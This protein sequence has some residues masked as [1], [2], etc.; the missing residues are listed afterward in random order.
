[1]DDTMILHADTGETYGADP[2]EVGVDALNEAGHSKRP[3]LRAIRANC[4]DCVGNN[5]SEV[6]KCTAVKCDM[7]PYRMGTNPFTGRKG[8]A[9]AFGN[10][11]PEREG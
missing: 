6:R 3:L 2:R 1:M 11:T 10:K 7:W 5:E 9:S 8:N 4:L